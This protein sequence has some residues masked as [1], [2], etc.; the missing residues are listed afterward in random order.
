MSGVT[1]S[2]LTLDRAPELRGD[3][4]RLAALIREGPA[5]AIAASAEGVLLD[6]ARAELARIPLSLPGLALPGSGGAILLGLEGGRAAFAVDLETLDPPLR[7]HLLEGRRTVTLREAGAILSHSE[8]A[9]AAYAVALL[10][11]HRRHPH[12]AVCGA[13]TQV[14]EG[15]YSRRCPACGA[16]HF[17]RTDPAV[18][19]LVH[20]G[21]QLLLGRRPN[22][23]EGQYSVLAGFVSPG[24][25]AEEAVKREVLEESGITVHHPVFVTSQPWPFPSSLMLGFE[26]GSDGGEPVARD[27]ELED[28]GWFTR[29]EVGAALAGDTGRL[30]LPPSVSIARFLI[31]RWYRGSVDI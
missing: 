30:R 11:W 22:W 9:L 24:E 10:N 14:A 19:M 5:V 27:D 3:P 7:T 2:G 23:P 21:D 25:S 1:F 13:M 15:G 8:A 18:I 6:Q 4:A 26:A 29:A 28:V 12:C 31:E 17:P 20:S 16:T